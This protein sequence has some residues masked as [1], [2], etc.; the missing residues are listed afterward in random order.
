MKIVATSLL[1]FVSLGFA[2]ENNKTTLRKGYQ[3]E[4]KVAGASATAAAVAY[5]TGHETI[6][7][8][9]SSQAISNA[10][11]GYQNLENYKSFE[12]DYDKSGPNFNDVASS[13]GLNNLP[14]F[15]DG[16]LNRAP[17]E[18]IN[19]EDLEKD[20]TSF[21]EDL[22]G[23]DASSPALANISKEDLEKFL[24]EGTM[25]QMPEMNFDQEKSETASGS[26][27]SF[28]AYGGGDTSASSDDYASMFQSLFGSQDKINS[29][30]VGNIPARYLAKED[31]SESI[32][33]KISK[34]T[35]KHLKQ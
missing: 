35:R 8:M 34:T 7:A 25:P 4:F 15:K 30:Y 13:L 26:N 19:K 3:T 1:L 28:M 14:G 32:W 18:N 33:D 10:V 29:D 22:K 2:A 21:M 20:M 11:A 9:F 16:K 27:L 23:L 5:A 12:P 17:A 24:K 31:D 6:A